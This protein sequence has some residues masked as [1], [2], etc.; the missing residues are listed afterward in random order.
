MS[1]VNLTEPSHNIVFDYSD[2]TFYSGMDL[3]MIYID[4]NMI[5]TE[6]F[7]I[8]NINDQI[9][10]HDIYSNVA[11]GDHSITVMVNDTGGNSIWSSTYYFNVDHGVTPFEV[12]MMDGATEVMPGETT[13]ASSL[14]VEGVTQVWDTGEI[15]TV[16][17]NDEMVTVDATGAFSK[18][19]TLSHGYNLIS[20]TSTNPFG[21]TVEKSYVVHADLETQLMVNDPP[22]LTASTSVTVSGTTEVGSSLTVNGNGMTVNADGTFSGSVSLTEG[23]NVLTFVTT[24]PYGNTMTVTKTVTSDTT[25]PTISNVTAPSET[26]SST[27]TVSGTVDD[28]HA[29]VYVNGYLASSEGST[30]FSANVNLAEGDNTVHIVAEDE[31]GNSATEEITITYTS[32]YATED[33]MD[34]LSEDI[35]NTEDNL[36][37]EMDDLN[38]TL[39]DDMED[40]KDI[41]D[42]T[43]I[44]LKDLIHSSNNELNN[45]IDNS[46]SNINDR[47]DTQDSTMNNLQD[48]TDK[49]QENDGELKENDKELK[50]LMNTYGIVLI[51][52]LIIGLVGVAV[53]L[54]SKINSLKEAQETEEP[55]EEFE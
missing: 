2:P 54:N 7:M 41:I 14:S 20:I 21:T 30:S 49:L 18:M 31:A 4:G 35:S 27:V 28:A 32:T 24:D 47:L 43:E 36:A 11:S 8:D 19:V 34:Q 55:E 5:P 15:S 1:M 17:I 38:K 25:A 22:E 42:Q 29:D 3:A 10:V 39:Y 33:D 48:D 16:H 51:I 44:S 12:H 46:T 40:L 45:E 50:G 52:L 53:M 6:A 37:G 9:T 23:E 13:G 26:T